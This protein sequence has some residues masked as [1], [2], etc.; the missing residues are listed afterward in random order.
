M[1]MSPTMQKNNNRLAD[2]TLATT[3]RRLWR[4]ACLFLAATFGLMVF[5][6]PAQA[7]PSFARQTQLQCAACH[8]A[9]PQL[10]A[11]GRQF[12]LQGYTLQ[13]INLS[14]WQRFSAMLQPS[15]THTN[16]DQPGGAAPHFN[17]ND[18]FATTQASL[19]Y[20]GRLSNTNDK[21]GAFV[22]VTYDDA[23]RLVSW[24]LADLR[25][26]DTG[27]LAGKPVSWGL[28]L[29][30]APS[31]TDLW[32]TSPVWGFPFSGS[33]LAPGPTAATLISDPFVGTVAGVGA[34]AKWNNSVYAEL[35]VY[36]T[37]SHDFLRSVGV[38]EVDHEIK[39]V[40]PYWRLALDHTSGPHYVE[41][42]TFGLYAKTYPERDHSAGTTDRYLDL[43]LD[44]QY[45][46][47]M[48][49]Y[50]LT[51]R[52]AWI[53]EDQ[54]L[55]ASTLLG[56]ADNLNNNLETLA[57]SASYLYDQTYG[58]DVG[59]NHI[60]GDTDATLY[61][62][63]PDSTYYTLQ[64][65]WL[66]LNKHAG[67]RAAYGMFNPKL[68]LQYTAYSKLDGVSHNASDNDTLYLQGWLTF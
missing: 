52:A 62:G 21:L 13:S 30:N 28:T 27:S 34:Y 57:L 68:S 48:P 19:F 25:W 53:H 5:A 46:Y 15:F 35:N 18:N 11:F 24:D 22:Q 31:V 10:N 37:L 47:T 60:N 51:T 43:G 45:E 23:S 1:K 3:S 40:A 8:T 29:N 7:I 44:L 33:G 63:S 50:S 67:P 36:K 2:V 38:D 49:S 39:G 55:R 17:D 58:V 20:G 54:K 65:D 66:P 4:R 42:G 32:N 61:G 12:K 16:K 59:Y 56:G 64:L 41:V 6:V 9:Y 26:A 14:P